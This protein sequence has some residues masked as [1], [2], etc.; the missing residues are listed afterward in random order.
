MEAV[1][2]IITILFILGWAIGSLAGNLTGFD[3]EP[4]L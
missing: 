3:N 4:K 2:A 1:T